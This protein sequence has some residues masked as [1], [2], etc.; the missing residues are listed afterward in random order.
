MAYVIN[1][2]G[3]RRRRPPILRM[4]CSPWHPWITEPA[5]RNRSALKKPCA[6]RCMIPAA[7]PP[8]PN[9][10]IIKPSCDT[11]EYASMRLMSSCAI[12]MSAAISAVVTPIHTT[13]IREGVTPRSE[14]H[15][16]EL[17]SPYDL[18]CRLLLEK[19]KNK[20]ESVQ[21]DARTSQ[22]HTAQPGPHPHR[23]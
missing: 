11:V 21:L 4:S 12:A 23:A 5:P 18:V 20:T 15:T 3:M 6:R 10:T 8:T 17:Q 1:V 13:T 16:S 2:T 7:T 22:P 14:E 19:K 9:E